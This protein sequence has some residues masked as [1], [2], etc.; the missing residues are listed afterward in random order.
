MCISYKGFSAWQE[1]SVVNYGIIFPFFLG[2]KVY[3][4]P[5]FGAHGY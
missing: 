4:F 1:L 2:P 5:K 3:P